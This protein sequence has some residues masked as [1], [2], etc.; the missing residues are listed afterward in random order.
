[1]EVVRDAG[2]EAIDEFVLDGR[3]NG[4]ERIGEVIGRCGRRCGVRSDCL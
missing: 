3:A 4:V 2:S 1:L